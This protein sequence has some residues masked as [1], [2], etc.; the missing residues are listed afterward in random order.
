MGYRNE[1]NYLQVLPASAGLILGSQLR[2]C[3]V[4]YVL[5]AYA[6]LILPEELDLPQV[7]S[8]LHADAVLILH[9]LE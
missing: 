8:V 2:R 4:I 5:P 3:F 7:H 9:K 1:A 6:G